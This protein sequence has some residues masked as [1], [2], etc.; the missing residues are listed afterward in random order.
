MDF[1][2]YKTTNLV[3]GRFYIGVHGSSKHSYYGSGKL[4]KAAIKKYGKEN[5]TRTT[6]YSNMNEEEAYL[7]ESM[8]VVTV[9]Q[10]PMSYNIEPGGQ[11]NCNLGK[12]VVENKIGIHAAT[13]EERSA[14]SKQMVEDRGIEDMHEIASIGGKRTSE[15]GGGWKQYTPEQRKEFSKRAEQT[16]IDNNSYNIFK[17][18]EQQRL[19]GIKGGK[20]HLGYKT[21]NDGVKLYKFKSSDTTDKE[22][23]DKEFELF[24][25]NNPQYSAG[26]FYKENKKRQ[27]TKTY[28]DGISNFQFRSSTPEDKVSTEKEF[29]Q[30][31]SSNENLKSGRIK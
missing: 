12:K 24:L 31:L 26:K 16:K 4:I 18:P 27:G 29:I 21:Y 28:N 22:L 17:D 2:V 10:N 15:N 1:I 19:N 23:T 14:W 5:F 6:L 25:S 8:V 20:A 7:I 9:D 13:F 3:N 11:G 30:F